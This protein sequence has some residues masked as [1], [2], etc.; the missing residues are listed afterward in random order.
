MH[1]A[2]TVEQAEADVRYGL[3]D[4]GRYFHH[5]LP[6]SPTGEG[7]FFDEML[8]FMRATG[9]G[10]VGTPDDAIRQI[11]RLRDQSGG[12][13]AFLV[14]GHEWADRDA[15]LRSYELLA[16]DVMPRFQGSAAGLERSLEWVRGSD[17]RFVQAAANA[18]GQ[19]FTDH[20]AEQQATVDQ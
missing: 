6:F 7:Q 14:F 3:E 17:G 9:F 18:I 20:Q 12:F 13:G 8:G 11:E 4:F 15:T 5:I 1:L 10:V 16:R 2:D 19:A